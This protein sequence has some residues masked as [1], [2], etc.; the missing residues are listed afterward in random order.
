MKTFY[1]VLLL[2]ILTLSG[3]STMT[4]ARY[5]ISAENN[6]ALKNYQGKKVNLASFSSA[7]IFDSNCRMMGSIE[8]ADGL[9]M[10]A[11][12]QKAFNQEFKLAGIYSLTGT[13]VTGTLNQIEF[14]STSGL[15][16]G[17]WKIGIMLVSS[18]QKTLQVHNVY[19]F[20]SGF[21]GITA[22]NQTAQALTPAVQDLIRKAVTDPKFI[23]LL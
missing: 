19:E 2:S 18:N 17:W 22:C 10:Q 11:F 23:D 6:Q 8:A 13:Q 5:S 12:I 9:S 1:T 16:S 3:C 21:D 15:T 20:K 14:S 7:T 4:P